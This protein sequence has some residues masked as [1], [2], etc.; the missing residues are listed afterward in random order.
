MMGDDGRSISRNVASLNILVHDVINLLYYKHRTDKRKYFYVISSDLKKTWTVID[1]GLQ[2]EFLWS[3]NTPWKVS[4]KLR[5]WTLFTQCNIGLLSILLSW[6]LF[7]SK[8]L[9]ILAMWLLEK[10]S[11]SSDFPTGI[12]LLKVNNRNTIEVNN[13]KLTTLLS[14]L[15]TLKIFHTLF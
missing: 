3:F 6:T 12:Y 1:R 5:I 2:I 7:G 13:I 4:K 9:F 8:W 14:L 15:F 10:F 11:E